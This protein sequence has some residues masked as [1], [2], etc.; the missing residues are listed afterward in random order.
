MPDISDLKE[1]ERPKAPRLPDVTAAQRATGRRLAAIHRMY[2][3]EIAEVRAFIDVIE[4]DRGQARALSEKIDSMQMA[5]N[6]RRFGALCGRECNHLFA[7]HGI[8]EQHMFPAVDRVAGGL[9]A[10]V[11]AKLRAEH[12]VVHALI[13]ELAN[14]TN[15]LKDAPTDANYL[16]LRDAFTRLEAVVKSHFRYEETELE[17]ALGLVGFV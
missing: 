11:V 15:A 17:E 16:A 9:F 4:N 8:E 2:L 5:Q 7:H 12:E 3:Q 6:L 1:A 14:G 10:K 13:L